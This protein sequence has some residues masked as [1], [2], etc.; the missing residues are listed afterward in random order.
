MLYITIQW[1]LISYHVNADVNLGI[2]AMENIWDHMQK[3]TH[4]VTKQ[5]GVADHANSY[6]SQCSAVQYNSI[7]WNLISYPVNANVNLENIWNHMQ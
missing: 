2:L 1:N 6:S 7:Q 5:R 3:E 4:C